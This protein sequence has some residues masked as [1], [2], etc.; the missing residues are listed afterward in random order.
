MRKKQAE[1]AFDELVSSNIMT[2]KEYGKAKVFIIN[3]NRFPTI[4]N[5]VLDEL[6]DQIKDLKESL[7]SIN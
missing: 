6:D 1:Q 5:T 7:N 4:D 2:L 3:Q